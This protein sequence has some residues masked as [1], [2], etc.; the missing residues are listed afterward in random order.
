MRIREAPSPRF[1]GARGFSVVPFPVRTLFQRSSAKNASQWSRS[2]AAA[3]QRRFHEPVEL[4]QGP[5]G[6]AVLRKYEI[7]TGFPAGRRRFWIVEIFEQAF[8]QLVRI[9][10]L[11]HSVALEQLLDR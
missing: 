11:P 1:R 10:D 4:A 7:S 5:A 9:R 6:G 2:H 3:G 8:G